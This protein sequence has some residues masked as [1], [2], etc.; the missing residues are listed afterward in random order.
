MDR[1]NIG[2]EVWREYTYQGRTVTI[3]DPQYLY[4]GKTTHRV[5]DNEGFVTCVPAPGFHGCALRWLPRDP[6]APVAF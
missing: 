5:V 6:D 3:F 4:V 1:L 2:D